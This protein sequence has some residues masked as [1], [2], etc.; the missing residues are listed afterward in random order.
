M[1]LA[2]GTLTFSRYHTLGELPHS[3]HDFVNRQLKKY[4][5]QELSLKTEEKSLGWT[6]LENPL[7]TNFEHANYSFAD[8]LIFSLRIDRKIIPPSLMKVKLLQAEKKFSTGSRKR[9]LPK[10]QRDEIKERVR[11]ELL[12]KTYPV[13]SFYEV[14]WSPSQKCL[15]FSSL[16]KKAAQEFEELFKRTFD[17][18]LS[19][20]VPWDGNAVDGPTA[21]KIASLKEGVFLAPQSTNPANPNPAFLGREFLTWLWFKSQERGGG[22]MLPG[23][24]DIEVNFSRRMV[25][26][27]G[28]G[29]YAESVVCQ[30]LHADLKE[31]KAAIREGKKIKEARIQLGRGADKW[32]FTLKVDQFQFQSLRLESGIALGEEEKDSQGRILER[33]YLIETALKTLDQIF[34][35]FLS[36]R[37]SSQWPSEEIPRL[38][39]W[40]QR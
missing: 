16:L 38:K 30:G 21:E 10:E 33:V 13:P 40:I 35:F 15:L 9:V 20:C 2:K 17:L 36:I 26:E 27:S 18:A 39:K 12:S 23:V 7:D 34:S 8:Y 31:G 5:F 14:C 4:A 19:P 24:G 29:E 11:L 37:M 3:F 22:I 32:E 28:A 1:G 25:L 6:S